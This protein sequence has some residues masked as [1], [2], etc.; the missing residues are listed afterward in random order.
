[1]QKKKEGVIPRILAKESL[2]FG[3]RITESLVTG[4][5]NKSLEHGRGNIEPATWG[6]S[7]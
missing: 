7:K 1:M 5:Q 4:L 2:N 3:K 6:L